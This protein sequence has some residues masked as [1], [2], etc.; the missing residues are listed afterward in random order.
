MEFNIHLQPYPYYG[1]IELPYGILK[2]NMDYESNGISIE[3]DKLYISNLNAYSTYLNMYDLMD[4]FGIDHL[5]FAKSVT[6]I[7]LTKVFQMH[8]MYFFN[9][10]ENQEIGKDDL[11]TDICPDKQNRCRGL[12]LKYSRQFKFKYGK[13]WFRKIVALDNLRPIIHHKDYRIFNETSSYSNQNSKFKIHKAQC[14][15]NTI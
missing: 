11:F 4:K 10:A 3:K 12:I 13:K 15:Q 9:P 14:F 5:H 7:D 2:A 8:Y 6:D 1:H